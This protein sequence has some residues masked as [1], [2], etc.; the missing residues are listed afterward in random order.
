[1]G[2]WKGAAVA[3]GLSAGCTYLYTDT[4]THAQLLQE[5]EKG[6]FGFFF[7]PFSTHFDFFPK[8]RCP[9]TAILLILRDARVVISDWQALGELGAKTKTN[10]R[11]STRRTLRGE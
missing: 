5:C 4:H 10:K 7:V 6:E 2:R 9:A 1:M 3:E 8:T 11:S